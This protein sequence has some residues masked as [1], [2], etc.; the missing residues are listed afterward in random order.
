MRNI[1]LVLKGVSKIL[2]D[3]FNG[4]LLAGKLF[5]IVIF[6]VDQSYFCEYHKRNSFI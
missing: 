6:F 3:Y 4:M 1:I 5:G 2:P